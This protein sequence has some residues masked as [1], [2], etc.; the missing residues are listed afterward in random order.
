MTTIRPTVTSR[1]QALI[2][3]DKAA[4]A[5]NNA[6]AKQEE[7]QRTAPVTGTAA[8]YD[9]ITG[10]WLIST[11]DGGTIRAQSLTDGALVG[12][13]LPVQ[14]FGDSQTSAVSAPPAGNAGGG[15]PT[16]Q[17]EAAQRDVVNLLATESMPFR[18]EPAVAA[19]GSFVLDPYQHYAVRIEALEGVSGATVVTI[20]AIGDVASVGEAISITLSGVPD[21]AVVVAGS[22]LLRRV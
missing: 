9:P 7:A 22:I 13:R 8:G 14:R 3:A 18:I 21:P 4:A 16:S 17:I 19:D 11:P 10:D 6:L 1:Q 12:K 5:G 20:P 15:N 2:N